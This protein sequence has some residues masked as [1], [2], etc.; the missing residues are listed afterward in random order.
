VSTPYKDR[1]CSN[2]SEIAQRCQVRYFVAFIRRAQFIRMFVGQVCRSSRV[3]F[4]FSEPLLSPKGEA[5]REVKI[6]SDA[7]RAAAA[8]G[9]NVFLRLASWR[10]C[11]TACITAAEEPKPAAAA[12]SKVSAGSKT[13]RRGRLAR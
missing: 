4:F 11:F 10:L 6:V 9:Q 13:S 3:Q 12:E 2:C 1:L 5:K 8:R 7:Q